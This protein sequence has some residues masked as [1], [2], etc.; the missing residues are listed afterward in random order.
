MHSITI[1]LQYYSSYIIR[2]HRPSAYT[3]I[4]S[5]MLFFYIEVNKVYL[6]GLKKMMQSSSILSEPYMALVLP[7]IPP[8]GGG[9]HLV[10]ILLPCADLNLS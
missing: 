3:N 4:H 2:R 6:L 8:L 7:P 9:C 5:S 10:K 1:Y